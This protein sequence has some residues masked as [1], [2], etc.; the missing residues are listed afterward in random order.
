M[1]VS[2]YTQHTDGMQ[3]NSFTRGMYTISIS[4]INSMSF[5]NHRSS[6]MRE[7]CDGIEWS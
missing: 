3:T 6:E 5:G 1:I 2:I 7:R 4:S